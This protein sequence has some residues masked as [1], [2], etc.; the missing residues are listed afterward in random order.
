MSNTKSK[1]ASLDTKCEAVNN[2]NHYSPNGVDSFMHMKDQ[3]GKGAFD[4]FLQG[5]V[6]K[7]TQRCMFKR[8]PVEDLCKAAFY[9]FH[10]VLEAETEAAN[11]KAVVD[12]LEETLTHAARHFGI[13]LRAGGDK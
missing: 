1:I 4:G 8:K 12:K 6:I 10:L 9:L 3:M 7:Y 5:N 11:R 13:S 2:P